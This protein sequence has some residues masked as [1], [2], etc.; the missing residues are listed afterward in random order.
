MVEVRSYYP[1]SCK[2]MNNL[3]LPGSIGINPRADRIIQDLFERVNYLTEE[4]QRMKGLID[5]SVSAKARKERPVQG[6]VTVPSPNGDGMIRVN[7]DGVIVSYVNPTWFPDLSGYCIWTNTSNGNII[8]NTTTETSLFAGATVSSNSTRIIKAG[9]LH[10]GTTYRMRVG[11][12]Y[13]TNSTPTG[14]LRLRLNSTL[15]ADSAAFTMPNTATA[16]PAYV[17]NTDFFF[18]GGAVTSRFG[19]LV[20]SPVTNGNAPLVAT[21]VGFATVDPTIDQTVDLTWEWGTAAA[22]SQIQM[23]GGVIQKIRG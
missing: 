17:F 14:R 22:A 5:S 20:L 3:Y 19:L 8:T 21:C 18:T 1:H 11:G 15:I 9:T 12:Y 7:E 13:A 10:N 4:N 23:F 16:G 2:Y 6:I